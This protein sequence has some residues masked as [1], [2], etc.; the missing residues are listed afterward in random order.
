VAEKYDFSYMYTSVYLH[1]AEKFP[2]K[3]C[4]ARWSQKTRIMEIPSREK[5]L[6]TSFVSYTSM[7]YGRT[8]RQIPADGYA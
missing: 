3:F 2:L 5:S 4:N 6:M 7:T 8:D 1:R